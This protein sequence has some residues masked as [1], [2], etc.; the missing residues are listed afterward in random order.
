MLINNQTLQ[1]LGETL[2]DSYTEIFPALVKF[3]CPKIVLN[4]RLSRCA[5]RSFQELNKIDLGGKF[6]V[7]HS[8][9]MLN[10]ILPHELAHQID[11]NLNGWYDRKSHHGKP[12][13]DIMVKIGQNPAAYHTMEL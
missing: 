11:Y 13:V 7:K 12:W 8:Y 1:T 4:N 3:D 9:N 6:F 5:G 2:W 10:V